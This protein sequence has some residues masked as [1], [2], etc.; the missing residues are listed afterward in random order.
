MSDSLVTV[1]GFLVLGS[2]FLVLYPYIFYPLTLRLIREDGTKARRVH[3]PPIGKRSTTY[4]IVLCAY[5]EERCIRQKIENCLAIVGRLGNVQIHAYSDGSTDRTNEILV[6]YADK[7]DVVI[8]PVRHGK[9]TGMNR[10]LERCKADLVVFTDANTILDVESF[11]NIQGHFRDA[12]VGCI[13]GHLIYDNEVESNVALMGRNYWIF[14]ENLK[15]LESQ[16]GSCVGADGS[17]FVIRR[18]LFKPLPAHIIDDMYTSLSIL[19]DGWRVIQVTDVIAKERSATVSGEEFARKVRI[20][21]RCFNCHRV[22]RSRLRQLPP[23][24][25]YK[26]ISHKVLRWFGGVFV[27]SGAVAGA[28]LLLLLGQSSI[29]VV[30]V[31]SLVAVLLGHRGK[32]KLLGQARESLLAMLAASLGILQSWRGLRYQVWTIAASTRRPSDV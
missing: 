15:L 30:G 23:T 26:Y 8:S 12:A 4:D 7:I 5:N 32:V 24:M 1:L 16:S 6:G 29:A 9:S 18:E 27:I 31:V 14:E 21:C 19:C 10:L 28:T 17:L 3:S 20:A 13:A 25:L 2:G 11:D 22:L